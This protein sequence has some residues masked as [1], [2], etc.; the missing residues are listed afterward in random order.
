MTH[1][2]SWVAEIV[3]AFPNSKGDFNTLCKIKISLISKSLTKCILRRFTYLPWT[4]ENFVSLFSV[5]SVNVSSRM[6]SI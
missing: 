4:L 1:L 5:F 6:D 2:H 3:L